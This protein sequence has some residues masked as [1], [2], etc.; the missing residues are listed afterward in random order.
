MSSSLHA[1]L[2]KQIANWSVLY[3]KLHHYHWFVN[4][5]HFFTLHAKYEEFYN[6]AARYV[7]ELAER[8]LAIGG[9]P[10]STMKACLETASLREASG[11]E[12]AEA[13]VEAIV[14]DFQTLIR[15]LEE[16]MAVAEKENDQPTLDMFVGISGSL[17]KHVWMLQAFLGKEAVEPPRRTPVMAGSR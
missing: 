9:K 16:G 12:S 8:L 7:D 1:V 3:K 6:E 4:G 14:A 10:V 15:E 11:G 2:N 5:P 17:Q 13:T